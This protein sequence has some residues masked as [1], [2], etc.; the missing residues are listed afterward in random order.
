MSELTIGTVRKELWKIRH[1]Y[2]YVPSYPTRY[3]MFRVSCEE[4]FDG[5]DG[6][7]L[8]RCHSKPQKY[9][10]EKKAIRF[11]R[12]KK[13]FTTPSNPFL[14]VTSEETLNEL[15]KFGENLK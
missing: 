10:Y 15:K 13:K 9:H 7:Y 12:G 4:E 6:E 3:K 1:G 5:D 11:R 14:T 8:T 2:W